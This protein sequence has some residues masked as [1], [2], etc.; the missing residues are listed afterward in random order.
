MFVKGKIVKSR[1]TQKASSE[2][3]DRG[4]TVSWT[5]Q[6]VQ[7]SPSVSPGYQSLV[8]AVGPRLNAYEVYICYLRRHLFP[9]GPIDLELQK[10]HVSDLELARNSTRLEDS[11]LFTR[12]ALT[13]A[14]LFFGSRHC[15]TPILV[16]GY[17]M[18]SAALQQ[19]NQALSIPG[20]HS[21]DDIINVIV[22][23]AMLELYLPSGP[24]NWLKHMLG[25]EKLLELRNPGLLAYASHQTLELYKGVRHMVLIA[26]LRNRSPSIFARPKWKAVLRTALSLESVEERE[27]H[28]VLADCSV[29]NA[30]NDEVARTWD[31]YDPMCTEKVEAITTK[32][33]ELLAFLQSWKQRWDH[34]GRNGHIM[35]DDLEAII[36]GA[37]QVF[38]TVYRFQDDSVARMFMTASK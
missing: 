36:A 12:A 34:D 17:S 29:L 8:Q 21:R 15:Q 24:K 35:E 7:D 14:T 25:L 22:I 1:R 26:S 20:Y 9:N 31:I 32:A 10:L 3:A 23:M 33:V 11:S 38:C 37:P 5:R 13:F 27:L 28:D 16:E 19:L 4:T 30:A 2:A 6:E 18:H